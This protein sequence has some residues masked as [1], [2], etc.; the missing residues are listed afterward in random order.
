M[1]AVSQMGRH[2]FEKLTGA[3]YKGPKTVANLT[4][5][6]HTQVRYSQA[7]KCFGA[8]RLFLSLVL[9]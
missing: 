5:S 3:L 2:T 7:I 1:M 6:N 9:P 4:L 8:T